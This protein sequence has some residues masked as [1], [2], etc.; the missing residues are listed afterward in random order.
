MKAVCQLLREPVPVRFFVFA[1]LCLTLFVS[2]SPAQARDNQM[3]WD[4]IPRAGPVVTP[5]KK[6]PTHPEKIAMSWYKKAGKT[7]DFAQWAALSPFL[8]NAK[9]S[10]IGGIISRESNRLSK[11][12][13]EFDGDKPLVINTRINMDDYSTINSTLVLD[14]FSPK[15]FFAFSIYGENIAIVPR[16]IKNFGNIPLPKEQMD[17]MLSK[18]GQSRMTA[19]VLLKPTL[20]DASQ[21]FIHDGKDYKLLL[22]DIAEINFW[23]LDEKDPQLLWTWRADWY[24]PKQDQELLELKQEPKN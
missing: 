16:D 6:A 11:A 12:Y 15:T 14:E 5:L 10:E 18:N 7:P 3:L 4:I 19:E 23:T 20:S 13:T 1:A 22:A 17:E 2:G 9:D 21:P 8:D 24:E